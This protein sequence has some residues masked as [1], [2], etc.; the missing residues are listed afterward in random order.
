MTTDMKTRS[1]SRLG[2][3][4]HLAQFRAQSSSFPV[5]ARHPTVYSIRTFLGSILREEKHRRLLWDGTASPPPRGSSTLFHR[6]PD[7]HSQVQG[8]P[9]FIILPVNLAFFFCLLRKVL[10]SL[11][12]LWS[13]QPPRD[14]S[15]Q[16]QCYLQFSVLRFAKW[17]CS[18]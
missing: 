11:N 15:I 3:S 4:T 1:L 13:E 14:I 9:V 7:E 5:A 6:P 8:K 10:W 18:A 12:H 17:I 2:R 16:L